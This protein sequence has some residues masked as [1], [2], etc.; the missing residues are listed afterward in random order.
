[1]TRT[2][3]IAA[4]Q[5]TFGANKWGRGLRKLQHTPSNGPSNDTRNVRIMICAA[6]LLHFMLVSLAEIEKDREERHRRAKDTL[7]SRGMSTAQ[8]GGVVYLLHVLFC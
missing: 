8:V 1:M 4:P 2:I 6:V 7:L 5:S 3:R